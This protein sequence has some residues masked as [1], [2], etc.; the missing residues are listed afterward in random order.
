MSKV[1]Y[2]PVLKHVK[3]NDSIRLKSYYHVTK[4][5]I[6]NLKR[7]N[8]R[9]LRSFL[10]AKS[11]AIFLRSISSVILLWECK[12]A[13]ELNRCGTILEHIQVFIRCAREKQLSAV[14]VVSGYTNSILQIVTTLGR[15][16][17]YS[18]VLSNERRYP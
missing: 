15:S 11:F 8:M 16:F 5:D 3:I 7:P 1:F 10:L 17:F 13:T 6:K 12:T 9:I 4:K 18:Q 14:A 2:L